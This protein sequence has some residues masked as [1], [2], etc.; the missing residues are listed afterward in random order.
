MVCQHRF[1]DGMARGFVYV[2]AIMDWYS[3]KVLA[4]RV[5][6][7]LKGFRWPL[8]IYLY[9]SKTLYKM[10]KVLLNKLPTGPSDVEKII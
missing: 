4:W 5:S 9:L 6:L 1:S 8:K 2:V 3:R 7:N 10:T